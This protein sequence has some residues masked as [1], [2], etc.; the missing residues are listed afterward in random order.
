MGRRW[1]CWVA[2][3][4][5]MAVYGRLDAFEP[6]P[7]LVMRLLYRVPKYCQNPSE[8]R[9][10][11]LRMSAGM[12]VLALH[13]GRPIATGLN[14]DGSVSTNQTKPHWIQA[15]H[16]GELGTGLYAHGSREHPYFKY[17]SDTRYADFERLVWQI[18]RLLAYQWVPHRFASEAEVRTVDCGNHPC[19][20]EVG[21]ERPGCI[22]IDGICQPGPR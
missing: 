14:R 2:G 6:P 18:P 7:F 17:L 5:G 20:V 9:T 11:T 22:C 13:L 21:C 10:L 16:E 15:G 4:G 8:R 1:G 19:T 3:A 12:T